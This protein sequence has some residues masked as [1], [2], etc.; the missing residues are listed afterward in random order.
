MFLQHEALF[1]KVI[2]ILNGLVDEN[3]GTNVGNQCC[4]S[5][6]YNW[7]CLEICGQGFE[8]H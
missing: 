2:F 7:Y 6:Y 5:I 1:S 4:Y 8:F 3:R